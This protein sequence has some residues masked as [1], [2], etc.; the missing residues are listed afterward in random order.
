MSAGESA[1]R[2]LMTAVLTDALLVV[3]EGKRL[4]S[5]RPTALFV[6]TL[7]WVRSDDLSWPF[8]FRNLCI[9]LDV[10]P[11]RLRA[12]VARHLEGSASVARDVSDGTPIRGR[13]VPIG[14]RSPHVAARWRSTRN[15]GAL[16]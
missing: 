4:P 9:A 10:D 11:E 14:T 16:R 13:V 6:E 3:T 12:C 8:S 7:A 1:E 2:A 15:V 5:G